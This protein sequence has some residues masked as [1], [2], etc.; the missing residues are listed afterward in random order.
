[1]YFDKHFEYIIW[2]QCSLRNYPKMVEELRIPRLA[3]KRIILSKILCIGGGWGWLEA[4]GTGWRCLGVVET[5]FLLR[6]TIPRRLA[7]ISEEQFTFL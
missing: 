2:S 4:V 1:M 5:Q 7:T 3:Q 6:H